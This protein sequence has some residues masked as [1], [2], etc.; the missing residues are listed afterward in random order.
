MKWFDFCENRKMLYAM[1][2]DGVSLEGMEL[3]T[4]MFLDGPSIRF[5][6][7]TFNMPSSFPR[8]WKEKKYNAMSIVLDFSIV[9]KMRVNGWKPRQICALDISKKAAGISLSIV[10]PDF[11]VQLE[12]EFLRVIEVDG[13]DDIRDGS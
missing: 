9:H 8:K 12:S 7:S 4:M 11:D 1:F 2:P 3:E 5:R 10:Q 6:M 13:Y